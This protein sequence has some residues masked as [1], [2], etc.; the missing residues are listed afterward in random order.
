M[1]KRET[2]RELGLSF[3]KLA[4]SNTW[5]SI[6]GTNKISPDGLYL[7]TSR[8][9]RDV[10]MGQNSSL[11]EVDGFSPE[12][13][14]R[15][16]KR[17]RK[18][19]EDRSG[20]ISIGEFVSIPELKENPLVKRLVEVFDSDQDGEVDFKEFVTG[21]AQF[22]GGDN[23]DR[24][25][26][27]LF[28]IYDLDSDGYISNGEL[29][30]VLKMMTGSNLKDQQLQQIV[31]K[32]I[33]YLDKDADGKIGFEEFKALVKSRSTAAKLNLECHDIKIDVPKF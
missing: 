31:D 14:Q 5:I 25:L 7:L 6:F 23:E 2:R 19:D 17:F 12:E 8:Q 24:R 33:N 3:P 9:D 22:K 27:F 32:T 16:E 15:L 30:Q 11:L 1:P 28:R 26:Q 4:E 10:I 20:S 21:L 29:F 18:L 13:V